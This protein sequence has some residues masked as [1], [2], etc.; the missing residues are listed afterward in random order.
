MVENEDI[1]IRSLGNL[2]LEITPYATC[3]AE[4]LGKMVSLNSYPL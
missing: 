4:Q 2:L 3:Q 1:F